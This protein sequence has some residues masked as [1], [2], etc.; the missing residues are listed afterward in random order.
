MARFVA[1]NNN[2]NVMH[3][4]TDGRTLYSGSEL[5]TS[6]S[7]DQNLIDDAERRIPLVDVEL[8]ER[9][10]R[11]VLRPSLP[12]LSVDP[13]CVALALEG[14]RVR[15]PVLRPRVPAV[16]IASDVEDRLDALG[17]RTVEFGVLEDCVRGS[18]G[19]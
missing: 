8:Q 17:K 10:V 9:D 11:C 7:P 13:P 2:K 5:G 12:Q 14:R 18:C 19:G 15:Q 1:P 4:R 16:L 6:R 3:G